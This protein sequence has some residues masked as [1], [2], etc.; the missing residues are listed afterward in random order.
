MGYYIPISLKMN[1]GAL[2][3]WYLLRVEKY[4]HPFYVL[5]LKNAS[6]ITQVSQ[7]YDNVLI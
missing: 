6:Y 1:F 5:I 2:G 4:L 3:T 7:G